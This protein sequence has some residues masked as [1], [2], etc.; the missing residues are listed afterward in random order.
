[1]ER[2]LAHRSLTLEDLE[3]YASMFERPDAEELALFDLPTAAP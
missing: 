2:Y 3:S 1:M